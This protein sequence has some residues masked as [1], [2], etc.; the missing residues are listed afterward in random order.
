MFDPEGRLLG[1]VQMPERFRPTHIG[2][3][4]VLGVARDEM[5]VERV[6]LYTLEKGEGL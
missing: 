2:A 5:D 3:D 4:F 1:S 6:R